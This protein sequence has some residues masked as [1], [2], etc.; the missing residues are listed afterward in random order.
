MKQYDGLFI[1]DPNREEAVKSITEIVKSN[2]TKNDGKI[3]KEEMWGKQKLSFE[4]KKQ[5]E[6]IYYKLEFSIDPSKLAV[7][8]N[9]YKLNQ[10]ILRTM[11]T[12]K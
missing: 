6:G 9:S 2:I 3:D 11:I 12:V 5:S 4:I 1:I 7:L 8:N 10:D